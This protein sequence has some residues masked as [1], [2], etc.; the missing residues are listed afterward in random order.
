M[1]IS[2]EEVFRD[3]L[4]YLKEYETHQASFMGVLWHPTR[5]TPIYSYGHLELVSSVHFGESPMTYLLQPY[6]GQYRNTY[7]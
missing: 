5:L 3:Y 1:V 4:K 6:G 7:L 2:N